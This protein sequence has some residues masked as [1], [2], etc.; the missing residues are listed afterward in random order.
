MDYI[1]LISRI[2]FGGF[3]IMSGWGHFKNLSGS[4]GYTASK[5]V[6]FPKASVVLSGIMM[7][8]GGLGILFGVYVQ[9]SVVLIVLC[10]IPISFMMHDYWNDKDVHMKMSNRVN[11]MKNVALIGGALAFLFITMPWPWSL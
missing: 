5:K 8:L 11:F 6:P 2:L 3:F 1:F 7:I 10:L 4:T 9:L